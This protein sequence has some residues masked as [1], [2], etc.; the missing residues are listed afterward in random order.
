M[1]VRRGSIL[2]TKGAQENR[3][4]PSI[5][6]LFR[7]AAVAY[8]NGVIGLLLTGYLDDGT[9]G[10]TAIKT[11][12]GTCVVQDPQDAAYPDMPRNVLNHVKVDYC[13][14]LADMGALLSKLVQRKLESPSLCPRT[15]PSRQRS[16]S[17]C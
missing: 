15:S 11:C 4:R 17:G 12:G 10:M 7:S 3:S 2:I 13:L 14:P 5:D 16:P 8:T 1:M 9:A 6:P